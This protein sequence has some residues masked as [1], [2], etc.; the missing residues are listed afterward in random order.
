MNLDLIELADIANP[1]LIAEALIKMLPEQVYPVPVNEIAIA[2]GIS[3]IIE[4]E[5]NSFE[6]ALLTNEEKSKAK[7]LVKKGI[8]ETRQRFTIA[9]ELGHYL[10]PYHIPSAK[11]F[12]CT[13]KDMREQDSA[14]ATGRP[15]WEAE[16]NTFA[17][18]LLMPASEFKQRFRKYREITIEMI[19]DL[20]GNFSVS[21]S[22]F[23]YRLMQLADDPFAA[24]ISHNGIVAHAYRH[25][26]FPRL[27][28]RHGFEM[29]R[30][31]QA[32]TISSP[33]G[34]IS[35]ADATDAANWL[36]NDSGSFEMYEQVLVQK[37][38]WHLTLLTVEPVDADDE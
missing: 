15:K 6:G 32:K 1:R 16:A 7:I 26:D 20:S 12:E 3:E 13:S 11:G 14:K 23:L 36:E 25:S 21:K 4:I 34:T 31:C 33:E 17:S 2:L 22:A 38:G 28:L 5:T 30:R 24:I 27:S 37:D 9:H 8:I 35:D 29:P 19:V 18:N 10:I